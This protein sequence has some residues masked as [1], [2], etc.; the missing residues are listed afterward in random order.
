M[1]HEGLA[2]VPGP[3]Q[4]YLFNLRVTQYLAASRELQQG[5]AHELGLQSSLQNV[6][7]VLDVLNLN[8]PLSALKQ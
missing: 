5:I 8:M 4:R 6:E 3:Q 2:Q 1:S 7:G